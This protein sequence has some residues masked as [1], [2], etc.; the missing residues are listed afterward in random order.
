M[1]TD[2]TQNKTAEEG[3]AEIPDVLNDFLDA[4]SA[5]A[6]IK[7]LDEHS[8]E[9]DEKMIGII[10]AS[11]D[12]PGGSGTLFQRIEYVHYYL[13]TRSRFETERLR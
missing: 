2:F 4:R 1:D 13:R 7:I 11:L 8:E 6:K 12:L 10:E 5:G 9:I 3:N